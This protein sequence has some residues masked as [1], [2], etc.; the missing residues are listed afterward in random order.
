MLIIAGKAM[1]LNSSYKITSM[2]TVS[3]K[4]LL[5]YKL[6]RAEIPSLPLSK[7]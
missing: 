7:E 2:I 3:Q 6:K 4:F 5:Q 1:S